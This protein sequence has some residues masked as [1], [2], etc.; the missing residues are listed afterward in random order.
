M[1]SLFVTGTDT[2]VGKTFISVALIELFKQQGLNV[3]GMKPI[4]SGCQ[5]TQAGLRNEDA[6]ALQQQANVELAY[7]LINPYAFAPA[8]APH[9]AAQQAATAIDI[10]VLK[11]HYQQIQAQ[12][13][14]VVVEGAG[15]WL[16]PLNE[17][18]TMADLASTLNL[19]VVL[20]VGIRLGCINHAL[21]SVAAIKQTGLSLLG[22][23]ANDL[24]TSPQAKAMVQ[25]LEQYIAA[26]CLGVV[27]QLNSEQSATSFL[28]LAI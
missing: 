25:T 14:V 27:P 22:W 18:D 6:L 10:N 8:I 17:T 19:P 9:I 4:A 28:N 23:V 24:E 20:V 3:A 16:V 15:G 21:L 26:P 7:E 12:A 11:S 13:D 1:T 2:E 5:Q